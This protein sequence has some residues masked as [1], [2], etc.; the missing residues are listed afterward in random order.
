MMSNDEQSKKLIEERLKGLSEE[1]REVAI[2]ILQQIATTG[3]SSLLD[4]IKYA[5][6]DEVPVDIETFLHDRNYLGNG[7]IDPE[8]RF[9]VWPY[10]ENTLKKIFPDNI[11]TAFN[12]IV[13]TGAI[14]IGKS[15][16]AVICVLYMLYR[17]LCLKDPYGYY[18]MQPIDKLS[19]SFMN[20]TIEN[21]KGVALDKM[22]QLILAS[23]WFMSHGQMAGTAN[24]VFRPEKHIEFIAASSNNQIIGRAIFYNFSDEVN[25]SLVNNPERQKK[26]MMKIRD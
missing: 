12:T 3:A 17:L 13:F 1:D 20:I 25:F 5:D 8:G 6:F 23:P 11:T 15:M 16:V 21:A 26:K 4:D 22:N 10:W 24:L 19:I 14:G 2:K 9:T 18:G 7:L